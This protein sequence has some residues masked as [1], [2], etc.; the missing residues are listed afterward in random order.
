MGDD[1]VL[2]SDRR[3]RAG[4]ALAR[5]GCDVVVVGRPVNLAYMTG[6]RRV[7]VRGSRPFAPLALLFPSSGEVHIQS[8]SLGGMPE[9][10]GLGDL[11]PQSWDPHR[12]ASEVAR[13]T[14]TP[15]RV[16]VD[17]MTPGW[18]ALLHD[19]LP[20]AELMP[21]DDALRSVR[22]VK[23]AEELVPLQAAV[24]AVAAGHEAVAPHIRPGVGERALRARATA[25][26][27]GIDV[28]TTATEVVCSRL[29]PGERARRLPGDGVLADGDGVLVD[30]GASVSG[31]EAVMGRTLPCGEV[32]GL[33]ALTGEWRARRERVAGACRPGATAAAVMDAGGAGA[34][35]YGMGFGPEPPLAEADRLEEGAVIAV[36]FGTPGFCARDMILVRA[37]G[38]EV[39]TDR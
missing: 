6:A 4:A 33:G 27:G 17:C 15:R 2:A 32:A 16:G 5:Q 35:L 7:L 8:A 20:A 21:I 12:L 3:R 34:V 26:M 22:L 19:A 14:G 28:S 1:A 36:A 23:T 39:L 30:L 38:G 25:S 18:A 37:D 9:G 24:D 13:L 29:R 31:Y 11:Y 10:V